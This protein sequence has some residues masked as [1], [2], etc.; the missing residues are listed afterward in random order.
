MIITIATLRAA[1]LTEAQILRVVEIADN[2]QV[3]KTRE[4]NRIYQRN[5][6]A[7]MK[8]QP[9]QSDRPDIPDTALTLSKEEKVY[10]KEE[11]KKVRKKEKKEPLP[12]NWQP[13][14][15]QRDLA[16]ADEFR[17]HARAKGYRY[18][19]WHAAYRNFQRSPYNARNKPG[20][21]QPS[22]D[23][24]E[25]AA[26]LEEFHRAQLRRNG[27]GQG[28]SKE[29]AAEKPRSDNAAELRPNGPAVREA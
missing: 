5:H 26:M 18:S 9:D 12:E 1:G 29:T 11:S 15:P 23:A 16:E 8:S 20:A 25:R 10:P 14:G 22:L 2:E 6:R 24:A 19:D 28:A 27:N 13:I 4:Q 3:A 21:P 17:D 7:R